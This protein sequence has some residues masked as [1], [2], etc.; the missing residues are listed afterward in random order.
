MIQ[1]VYIIGIIVCCIYLLA[2]T[3]YLV[4]GTIAIAKGYRYYKRN[5]NI[6]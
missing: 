5:K 1:T 6:T 2:L 3:A 4:A